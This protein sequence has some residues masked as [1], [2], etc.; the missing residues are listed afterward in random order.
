MCHTCQS[1]T[2]ALKTNLL[3]IQRIHLYFSKYAGFAV[4]YLNLGSQMFD[5]IICFCPYFCGPNSCE[6]SWWTSETWIRFHARKYLAAIYFFPNI[7]LCSS[8]SSSYAEFYSDSQELF[9]GSE[10][11]HENRPAPIRHSQHDCH[12]CSQVRIK[13]QHQ[14]SPKTLRFPSFCA[15][16]D[17]LKLV[18]LAK[19][20]I[21]RSMISL[22]VK[23]AF[24]SLSKLTISLSN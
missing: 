14:R 16:N 9:K 7:L 5:K 22:G 8:R 11:T 6:I 2:D 24:D 3:A 12:I 23:A 18:L 17:L 10:F 1:A 21:S 15:W 4:V 20:D 19:I 13:V